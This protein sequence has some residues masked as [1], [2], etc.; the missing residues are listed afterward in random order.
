M[1]W[2]IQNR[3]KQSALASHAVLETIQHEER[4]TFLAENCELLKSTSKDD[5]CLSANGRSMKQVDAAFYLGDH[6]NHHQGNNSDLCKR[7]DH[8]D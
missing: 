4:L 1:T 8:K 2:Q 7:K 5:T 6:F 3:D